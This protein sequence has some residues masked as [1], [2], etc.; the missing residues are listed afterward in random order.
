MDKCEYA[1]VAEEA[2]TPI[3]EKRLEVWMINSY[4]EYQQTGW[5][6]DEYNRFRL[7]LEHISW[8]T[9]EMV[10]VR[11]AEKMGIRAGLRRRRRGCGYTEEYLLLRG[12]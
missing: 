12:D 6:L 1:V 7:H 2:L 8:D 5:H 10:A 3:E 4:K 11:I 9:L